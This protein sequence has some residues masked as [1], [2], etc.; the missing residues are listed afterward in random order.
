M[1][2][3]HYPRSKEQ[4]DG[5]KWSSV[6]DADERRKLIE[7]LGDTFGPGFRCESH[8]DVP[9]LSIPIADGLSL[10]SLKM[11]LSH[12]GFIAFSID[13]FLTYNII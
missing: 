3:A 5:K 2:S 1:N 12:Q 4:R 7:Y 9:L 10:S 13:S 6:D 11:S 8:S